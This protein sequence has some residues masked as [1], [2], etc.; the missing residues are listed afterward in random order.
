MLAGRRGGSGV[1]ATNGSS[2]PQTGT[3][4]D[5]YSPV[6]GLAPRSQP[7]VAYN[8]AFLRPIRVFLHPNISPVSLMAE[9]DTST[10]R[11]EGYQLIEEEAYPRARLMKSLCT[12]QALRHVSPPANQRPSEPSAL[13]PSSP[14]SP[15]S[16]AP[17]SAATLAATTNGAA[18]TRASHLTSS[19]VLSGE[20]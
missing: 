15:C 14:R 12:I 2:R 10:R 6:L 19:A 1:T 13:S 16:V 17:P 7:L 5:L 4:F 3:C 18:V 11:S 9:L 8:Y 20:R